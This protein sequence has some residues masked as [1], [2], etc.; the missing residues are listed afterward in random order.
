[1]EIIYTHT[2]KI[3][4]YMHMEDAYVYAEKTLETWKWDI[5]SLHNRAKFSLY[6]ELCVFG[7][8]PFSL[9]ALA[10]PTA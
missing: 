8:V 1:M 10:F 6:D 7:K 3:H 4:I 2:W 5:K 9:S